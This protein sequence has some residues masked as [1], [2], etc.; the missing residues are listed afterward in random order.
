ME[1]RG[2][3]RRKGSRRKEGSRALTLA[4]KKVQIQAEIME[5]E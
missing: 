2:K 3:R 5:G 4:K 1:T